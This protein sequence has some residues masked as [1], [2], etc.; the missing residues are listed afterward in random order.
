[1]KGCEPR[2]GHLPVDDPCGVQEVQ[3]TG[4]VQH[5][6]SPTFVP[7]QLVRVIPIQSMP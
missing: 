1:V 3:A 2:A 7:C 6:A 4:H 5:D